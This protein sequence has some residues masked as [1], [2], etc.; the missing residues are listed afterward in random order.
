MFVGI[1]FNNLLNLKSKS[2][3]S[4]EANTKPKAIH[5]HKRSSIQNEYGGNVNFANS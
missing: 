4:F 2:Q 1:I 5:L 3:I